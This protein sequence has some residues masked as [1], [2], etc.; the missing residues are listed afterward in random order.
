M[1]IYAKWLISFPSF[2]SIN[3]S[4]SRTYI[5]RKTVSSMITDNLFE[6]FSPPRAIQNLKKKKPKLKFYAIIESTI[7]KKTPGKN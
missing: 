2:N 6:I 7:K 5:R 3:C 1:E 4:F